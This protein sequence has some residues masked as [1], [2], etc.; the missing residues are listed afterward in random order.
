MPRKKKD[1]KR[2]VI[3]HTLDLIKIERTKIKVI[4]QIE[5]NQL[6]YIYSRVEWQRKKKGPVIT[7]EYY[8]LV[9]PKIFNKESIKCEIIAEVNVQKE[10]GRVVPSSRWYASK[11][12]HSEKQ[13]AESLGHIQYKGIKEVRRASRRDFPLFINTTYHGNPRFKEE[14]EKS[15]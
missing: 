4:K 11:I 12:G 6:T 1:L 10:D 5:L 13:R 9:I 3:N 14:F 8:H 7:N 2:E 15:Q